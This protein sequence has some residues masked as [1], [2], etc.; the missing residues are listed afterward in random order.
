MNPQST[1]VP[2]R[3]LTTVPLRD[4]RIDDPWFNRYIRLVNEVILPYQWAALN[5][6]V[7]GAEPSHAVRNIRLAAGL[8]SG[9][10][11]G[12]VFQD[13][14]AMKWLEAVGYSLAVTPNPELEARADSLIELIA[15]AQQ[16]DG[17]FN[18]YFTVVAPHARWK[19]LT[20]A[21][22]LYVAGHM[23]EAAIAYYEGTGK[24]RLLDV[25]IRFADLIDRVFGHG[26]GQLP[27]YPGHQE[28]ELALVRL[29]RST[30]ERRY[31]N[32]ARFFINERGREPNYFTAEKASSDWY[33]LYPGTRSR[34][35]ETA[36]FQAHLPVREQ[37][38]AVGHAVRATYMYAAMA[39]IAA[40]DGDSGLL[41]AAKRLW[42]DAAERQMYITGGIGQSG[43][44][45]RFTTAYDL[46]N[47]ANYSET[48]ASIGLAL[49]SR[50]LGNIERDSRYHDV[51]ERT[52][53]NGIVSGLQ[54]DGRRFFYVNP[55]SIWPANCL[56]HTMRQHVR[57]ERQTWFGCAC[58][59]PNIARTL[60]GLGEYLYGVD[61]ETGRIYI[62]QL[63]GNRATV[64]LAEHSV[65][66]DL[67]AALSEHGRVTLRV[68]SPRPISLAI[69]IPGWA[70]SVSLAGP[71][72][73]GYLLLDLA[74]GG[75]ELDFEF[76]LPPELVLP[77]PE[78]R[79]L[80]GRYAVMRG[81]LVY[82]LEEVD[83]GPELEAL[84]INDAAWLEWRDQAG[85]APTDD[86]A[87]AC[88]TVDDP[89]LGRYTRIRLPGWRAEA[90]ADVP[91]YRPLRSGDETAAGRYRPTTTWWVPYALWCHRSP[92]EMLVWIR[93]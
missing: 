65:E 58:C 6:A 74:A 16:P 92:G 47:D 71:I 86:S 82:C 78:A 5:D 44:L 25:A 64:H 88:L 17:Y 51:V 13:S 45:E 93:E 21:H 11:G 70:D 39:D 42:E 12:P 22:E 28:I 85:K 32:L 26:E 40:A 49:F 61:E 50:R 60:A 81:P 76:P 72:E 89:V 67:E 9:E 1:P 24:R 31:L 73:N 3:P 30:G 35:T 7:P 29:W 87:P 8:E 53:F 69:R 79:A 37:K 18:S 33:E 91:L 41:D 38:T 63:I 15:Q 14:D 62:H 20:D 55:M 57:P 36:Y 54:L 19:N 23:I 2:R 10:Y 84:R 43:H 56:P 4:I 52:L 75:H 90:A 59:P 80:Q 48:C 66:L 34:P 77:H 46:P 27:G 83:N 68:S